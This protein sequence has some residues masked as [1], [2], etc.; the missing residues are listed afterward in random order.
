MRCW[1]A[2][3]AGFGDPFARDPELVRLDLIDGKITREAADREYEV[4]LTEAAGIDAVATQRRRA[5]LRD[6]RG[7]ID[8]TYDRGELGRALR[9]QEVLP[10]L[11]ARADDVIE[12]AEERR[13][14][15]LGTVRPF[16]AVQT[17]LGTV[18]TINM[19]RLR[20]HVVEGIRIAEVGRNQASR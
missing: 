1:A 7:P 19:T 20:L 18:E 6:A 17:K 9:S 13:L 4:V 8:W 15:L 10:T 5:E 12:W 14:L 16:A 2:G 3:G 11:L